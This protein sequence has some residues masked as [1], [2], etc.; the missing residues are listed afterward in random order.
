[1]ENLY[2]LSPQNFP[3][4]GMAKQYFLR[5]LTLLILKPGDYFSPYNSLGDK[6]AEELTFLSQLRE[7]QKQPR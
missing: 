1:M 5:D 7:Y 6:V 3:R 2:V 4:R